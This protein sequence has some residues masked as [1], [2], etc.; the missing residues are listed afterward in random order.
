MKEREIQKRI[1]L[2]LSKEF[3][4]DGIFWTADTG[5]A[6]SMD[7]KRTIRF[8]IPGQPDIQGVLYGLWIGIEVKTATGKQR[9]VQK[10]FQAAV[11]RAGGI[12]IVA[13]SPDEAILQIKE[14]LA[15]RQA[16]E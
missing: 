15:I 8:G 16:A 6:K 9:D 14:C 11:E 13:R 4:P 10:R 5:V 2:A 12:Y 1:L 3:H 7:G